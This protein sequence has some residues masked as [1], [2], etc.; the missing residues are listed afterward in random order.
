MASINLKNYENFV[1]N[2][3]SRIS[4]T[5]N[6]IRRI[7]HLI[8]GRYKG[9]YKDFDFI[10]ESIYSALNILNIYH[11]S[12]FA[13]REKSRTDPF[14]RYNKNLLNS[15]PL[16]KQIAYSL[17]IIKNLEVLIEIG[18][19]R[20]FGSKARYEVITQIEIIKA[21]CRFILFYLSN[22]RMLLSSPLPERKTD[23][24]VIAKKE[25]EENK[26][27]WT[28][29]RTGK[30]IK[31]L[32]FL[33]G[34]KNSQNVTDYVMS[35]ALNPDSA[36][37]AKDL[38]KPLSNIRKIGEIL[39]IIKPVAYLILLKKYGVK[40]WKPWCISLSMEL[41]CYATSAQA[42]VN[43]TLTSLEQQEY[44]RRALLLKN[45]F[46]RRPFF[47]EFIRPNIV[48]LIDYMQDNFLLKYGTG[49]LEF[50]LHNWDNFYFATSGF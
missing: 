37:D 27:T 46:I 48:K 45:Y 6:V 15:C 10:A 19:L 25:K 9:N 8:H 12:I 29:S 17:S 13:N 11:E 7:T 34:A 28:G 18:I 32:D 47:D 33:K 38:V 23:P 16:Y 40:S 24:S 22:K 2:N 44:K 5:D 35:Q 36:C 30:K 41:I 49:F 20:K 42:L 31:N 3:S 14:N 43:N 39:Y 21:V 50:N 26:T 1:F 4:S